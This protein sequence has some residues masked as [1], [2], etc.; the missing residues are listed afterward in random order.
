MQTPSSLP[1]VPSRLRWRR[2]RLLLW[3]LPLLA[4]LFA[5][6]GTGFF[7]LRSDI[8]SFRPRL[9]KIMKLVDEQRAATPQLPSFLQRC[10]AHEAGNDAHI[11]RILLGKYGLF[12]TSNTRRL[13]RW[14]YWQWSLKWHLSEE[15][16]QLLYCRFISDLENHL[17]IQH[18]AQ[19]LYQKPLMALTDHELASLVVLSRSPVTY[20]RD[21]AKLNEA[22][23]QFLAEMR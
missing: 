17:G 18:V 10:L 11:A 3:L 14:K 7:F 8:Y 9:P 19:K 1:P 15:E 20:L 21:A 23:E 16:R 12:Q 2:V 5:L 4:L 22:T 6:A 13:V